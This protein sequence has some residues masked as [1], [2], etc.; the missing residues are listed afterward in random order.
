MSAMRTKR[1]ARKWNV[2]GHQ[3]SARMRSAWGARN[4]KRLPR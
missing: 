4:A 2:T 1:A 3:Y